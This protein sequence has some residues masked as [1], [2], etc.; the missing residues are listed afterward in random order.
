MNDFSPESPVLDPWAERNRKAYHHYLAAYNLTGPNMD[1]D[2]AEDYEATLKG[3]ALLDWQHGHYYCSSLWVSEG[4]QALIV[5]L[6][7]GDVT[8]KMWYEA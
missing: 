1:L 4:K 3:V 6:P 8:L 7:G 5:E 2:W